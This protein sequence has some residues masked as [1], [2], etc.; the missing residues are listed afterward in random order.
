LTTLKFAAIGLFATLLLAAPIA[1]AQYP[2]GGTRGGMG[3]AG[4]S[5]S[6]LP[7]SKGDRRAIDA[8]VSLQGQVQMQLGDLQEELKLTPAQQGSWGAY[9]DRVLKLADDIARTRIA[10]RKA[11]SDTSAL[12]QFD[13]L[14][15]VARNRMTAVEEI[16]EAGKALYAGLSPEQRRIADRRLAPIALQLAGAG[17]VTP[18]AAM[19][20]ATFGARPRN[21]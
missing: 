5:P 18:T 9:S 3:G 4:G 17:T 10:A 8:P 13:S 15:D 7:E 14:A 11:A 1:S 6:K 16:A 21:P 12:Q 19:E 20:D 2:G